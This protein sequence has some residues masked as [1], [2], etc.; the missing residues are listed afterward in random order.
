[1]DIDLKKDPNDVFTRRR[2]NDCEFCGTHAKGTPHGLVTDTLA[3]ENDLVVKYE[4][5]AKE[6]SGIVYYIDDIGNVYNTEDVLMNIENPRI[7]AKYTK[8]ND[9]YTIPEFNLS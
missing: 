6:I 3:D 1:M 4:V 8:Q 9:L 2:K 7:V 5:F